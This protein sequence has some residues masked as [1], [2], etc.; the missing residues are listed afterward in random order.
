MKVVMISPVPFSTVTYTNVARLEDDGEN[1][2]QIVER[3][4]IFHA[5]DRTNLF[6]IDTTRQ[7]VTE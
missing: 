1:T 4:G 2:V 6:M 7:E 5:V 3:G